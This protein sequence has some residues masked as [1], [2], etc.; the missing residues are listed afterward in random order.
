VEQAGVPGSGVV[1]RGCVLDEDDDRRRP[2]AEDDAAL[3]L[4]KHGEGNR[5]PVVGRHH[6]EVGT[7]RVTAPIEVSAPSSSVVT[8]PDD[9]IGVLF[10]IVIPTL[11]AG[12]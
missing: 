11:D 10:V 2:A 6:V 4:R 9:P 5:I 7:R 3:P 12:C 8:A 1:Q